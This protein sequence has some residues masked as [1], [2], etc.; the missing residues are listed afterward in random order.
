MAPMH[1]IGNDGR[2]VLCLY[3]Q[4]AIED[5]R[6]PCRVQ[7]SRVQLLLALLLRLP[8]THG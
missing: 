7:P 8:P 2:C 3:T 4:E 1:P 6:L 5:A